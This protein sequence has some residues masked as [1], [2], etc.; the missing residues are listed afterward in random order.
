VVVVDRRQSGHPGQ[1]IRPNVQW[2]KTTADRP[3]YPMHIQVRAYDRS[4]LPISGLAS[5][6]NPI[7]STEEE[8]NKPAAAMGLSTE[9]DRPGRRRS[10]LIA[11]AAV[12]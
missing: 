2:L 6:N 5:S 9:R 11:I 8:T 3:T 7:A 4:G 1:A 10:V 12:V